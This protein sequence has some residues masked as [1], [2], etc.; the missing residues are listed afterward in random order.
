M[1]PLRTRATETDHAKRLQLTLP[2]LWRELILP[3]GTRADLAGRYFIAEIEYSNRWQH[4][5]AQ[6]L[7]YWDQTARTTTPALILLADILSA[8]PAQDPRI[9]R[10]AHTVGVQTW[11]WRTDL[12]TWI[13]GGPQRLP[14]GPPHVHPHN[15]DGTEYSPPPCW[16]RTTSRKPDPYRTWHRTA[17]SR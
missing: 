16:F 7:E 15:L 4:G 17:S 9:W 3:N 6:V 1:K 5:L 11:I 2:G 12:Q 13:R 10:L 8:G 14:T